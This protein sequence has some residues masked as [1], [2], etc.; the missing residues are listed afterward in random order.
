MVQIGRLQ[1]AV[2]IG[3]MGLQC[4]VCD[5]MDCGLSS[6]HDKADCKHC[7]YRVFIEER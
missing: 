5:F 2:R 7:L 6:G 4:S 3:F 1:T